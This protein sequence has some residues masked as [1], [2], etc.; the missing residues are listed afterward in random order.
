MHMLHVRHLPGVHLLHLPREHLAHLLRHLPH[1]RHLLC[2]MWRHLTHLLWHLAHLLRHQLRRQLPGHLPAHVARRRSRGRR[3]RRVM[4]PESLGE[5]T[6]RY[7]VVGLR[8][9]PMLGGY[10]RRLCT[11]VLRGGRVGMRRGCRDSLG[12]AARSHLV[13]HYRRR[14]RVR[15]TILQVRV[16][17]RLSRA[18]SLLLLWVVCIVRLLWRLGP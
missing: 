4:L 18:R 8:R 5:C 11:K 2:H 9:A 14:R 3:A 17:R 13:A 1:L 7:E 15:R 6:R 16:W 10:R 12:H